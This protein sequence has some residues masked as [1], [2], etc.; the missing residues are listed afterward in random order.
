M[1][2]QIF[3]VQR[4]V[5]DMRGDRPWLFYNEDRSV[6]YM[7]P[8]AEVPE[9]VRAAVGTRYKAFLRGSVTGL[10]AGKPSLGNVSPAGDQPW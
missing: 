2:T 7:V 3:K 4:P 5:L 1:T 10:D 8:E 9:P 6:Q